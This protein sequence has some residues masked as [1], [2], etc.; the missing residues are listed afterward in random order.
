MVGGGNVKERNILKTYAWMG[1][2]IKSV[3]KK[4]VVGVCTR[5]MWL[6][7]GGGGQ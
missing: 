2:N 1:D 5:I 3:L 6:R 7:G 4:K